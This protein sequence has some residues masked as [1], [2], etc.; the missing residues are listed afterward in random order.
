[1]NDTDG[2]GGIGRSESGMIKPDLF[3]FCF[4]V[5]FENGIMMFLGLADELL[6]HFVF[7]YG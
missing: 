5:G 7:Y 2:F 6:M 4:E 3:F 1:M